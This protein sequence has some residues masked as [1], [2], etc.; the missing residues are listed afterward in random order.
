MEAFGVVA[1]V[2]MAPLIAVQVMGVSYNMKLKK[3]S[4]PAA[5]IIGIDDNEILD[6]EED[7]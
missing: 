4:T 1:M 6:F 5:A 2:A 7:F 3:A